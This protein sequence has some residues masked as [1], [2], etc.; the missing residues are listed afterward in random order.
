MKKNEFEDK[1]KKLTDELNKLKEKKNNIIQPEKKNNQLNENNNEENNY[2]IS[3]FSTINPILNNLNKVSPQKKIHNMET[4]GIIL[5]KK[6]NNNSRSFD[7]KN[8]KNFPPEKCGYLKRLFL[9]YSKDNTLI[10]KDM[11]LNAIEYKIKIEN[12]KNI[13]LNPNEKNIIKIEKEKNFNY[14]ILDK[15]PFIQLFLILYE[16]NID[17]VAPNYLSYELFSNFINV[18][19]KYPTIK[20]K[21]NDIEDDFSLTNTIVI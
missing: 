19:K 18:I 9:Y 8:S 5:Y 7:Y 14:S 4:K 21:E 15:G 13:M 6:V 17:I 12:I 16:G 11:R 20:E 3:A 1:I 10:I 2:I